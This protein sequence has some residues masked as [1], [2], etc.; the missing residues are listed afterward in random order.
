MPGAIASPIASALRLTL[1]V[2]KRTAISAEWQTTTMTPLTVDL[3]IEK[4]GSA[5]HL[6]TLVTMPDELVR[7]PRSTSSSSFFDLEAMC[8]DCRKP[9]SSDLDIEEAGSSRP[10]H[11]L[12]MMPDELV[13]IPRST[14]SSSFVDLEAMCMACRKPGSSDLDIE[15][16]G[17]SRHLH[18]LVTMP[19]E[20]V[21]IPRSMS[22]SSFVD[23]EAMSMDCRTPGSSTS[24]TATTPGPFVALA[25]AQSPQ[26][27]SSSAGSPESSLCPSL[28]LT[29]SR[30]PVGT[31]PAVQATVQRHALNDFCMLPESASHGVRTGSVSA[32]S[33]HCLASPLML[34]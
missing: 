34:V 19:D 7:I 22:C 6:H 16:A 31:T 23:L 9:G 13:R 3:D 10:L 14:S 15:E 1:P 17:S 12:V 21:K 30:T 28:V 2:R 20:L 33:D 24:T 29:V 32:R 11:T 5:R 26:E 27:R 8:M 25:V 18:T 4:A